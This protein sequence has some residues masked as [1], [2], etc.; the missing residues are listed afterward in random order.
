[1]FEDQFITFHEK[2]QLF[3]L[4]GDLDARYRQMAGSPWGGST[5]LESA[6]KLILDSAVKH[7]VAASEMPTT[8]IIL[9]DMQFNMCDSSR[10]DS[11]FTMIDRMYAEAGYKRPKIVYWNLRDS[12]GVPVT[13]DQQ[14]TALVSGFSPSIMKSVLSGKSCD[15]V[16]MMLETIMVDR[17]QL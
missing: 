1:V 3:S 9:S 13:F 10:G 2:P 16:A 14:G 8:M 6:F 4:K 17:Y 12:N 7:N 5:N 15:P 11:S